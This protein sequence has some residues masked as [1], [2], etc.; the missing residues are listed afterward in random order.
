MKNL[1]AVIALLAAFAVPVRADS[2]SDF[3][4]SISYQTNIQSNPQIN[5]AAHPGA[6]LPVWAFIAGDNA[7]IITGFDLNFAPTASFTPNGNEV[8]WTLTLGG[9]SYALYG[10]FVPGDMTFLVPAF[11]GSEAG[12]LTVGV[13]DGVWTTETY[14]FNVVSGIL[15]APIA[16]PDPPGTVATPEPASLLLVGAGFSVVA[17]RMRAR[18]R[19]GR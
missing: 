10:E 13:F 6:N 19:A 7:G 9:Q 15:P 3:L 18:K 4:G 12:V 17:L 14:D 11:D 1:I 8:L 5:L 16:A 2:I